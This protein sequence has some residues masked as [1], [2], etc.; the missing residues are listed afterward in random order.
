[1]RAFVTE[2]SV[3]LAMS[4]SAPAS[5]ASVMCRLSSCELDHDGA[6]RYIFGLGFGMRVANAPADLPPSRTGIS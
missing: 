1:M 4:S 6:P 5:K 2:K 3:A